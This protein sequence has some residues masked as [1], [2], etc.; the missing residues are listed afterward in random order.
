MSRATSRTPRRPAAW[1]LALPFYPDLSQDAM[2]R[3]V[4]AIRDFFSGSAS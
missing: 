2:D 4:D 3:V 1:A